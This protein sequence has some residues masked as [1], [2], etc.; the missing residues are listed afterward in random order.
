ME[1]PVQ[2]CQT[3]HFEEGDEDM[4][5]G[6][7]EDDDSKQ[8]GDACV[9]DS[10]SKGDQG[11]LGSLGW[12]PCKRLEPPPPPTLSHG[13]GMCNVDGVV[14]AEATSLNRSYKL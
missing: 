7:G 1:Y 13:E 12:C 10:R 5:A 3:E 4:G 2:D 8:C 6:E 9:D 14:N 11:R